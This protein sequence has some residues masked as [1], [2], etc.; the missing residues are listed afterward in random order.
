MILFY[1]IH[2]RLIA[3]GHRSQKEVWCV[4]VIVAGEKQLA[5][6]A[7]AALHKQYSPQPRTFYCHLTTVT[8]SRFR[9]L[10]GQRYD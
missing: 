7:T 4:V 5:D 10:S 6:S 3:L 9:H 2:P 1:H 8:V